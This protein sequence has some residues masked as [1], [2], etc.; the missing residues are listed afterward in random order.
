MKRIQIGANEQ[1]PKLNGQSPIPIEINNEKPRRR[2]NLPKYD[3]AYAKRTSSRMIR[4]GVMGASD[5]DSPTEVRALCRTLGG[6]IASTGHCLL[7]GA[8]P[9]L[10]HE[11]VKGAKQAGG[12]IIGISPATNL[13]EHVLVFDSPY[14]EYDVMIY[15]GL[16]LMGR[17]LINIRSSDI[18]IIAGGHADTLGEFAI[19]YEEGKVIGVLLG[20]GGVADEIPE[21]LPNLAKSTTSFVI[22]ERSPIKLVEKLLYFHNVWV[23]TGALK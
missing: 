16:G 3:L 20:S 15:T 11:A 13:D 14:A 22:Y 19:A 7:T 10:P 12:H 4:F 23:A 9:G 2:R 6:A 1:V 5:L 17:E 21:L 18:V 8:C